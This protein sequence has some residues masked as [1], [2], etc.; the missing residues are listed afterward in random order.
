MCGIIGLISQFDKDV[1]NKVLEGLLSLQ[2]RGQDSSGISNGKLCIKDNG[3]A[4]NIFNTNVLEKLKSNIAI[5]HVRYST[6]KVKD[7]KQIQPFVIEVDYKITLVHNG[8]IINIDYMK[9][10]LSKKFGINS[11][12]NSDSEIL[13][14]IIYAKLYFEFNSVINKDTIFQIVNFLQDNLIGSFSVIIIIEDLVLVC[15]RDRYGIRPLLYGIDKEKNSHLFSSESGVYETVNFEYIRDILPGETMYI[16]NT[17]GDVYTNVNP[18]SY[19]IP[20]I[21]E[22]LYFARQDSYINEISVYQSRL[23]IGEL[24]GKTILEKMNNENFEID[25][26]VP[27]PDTSRIFALGVHNVLKKPYHEALVKNRY[28][29]RTFIL[30]NENEINKNIKR[31]LNTVDYLIKDK[32]VM[33]VDDSIVRGNTSKYVVSLLK[34]AGAKKVYIASASPPVCYPN[35]FG[36]FIESSKECIAFNRSLQEIEKILGIDKLIYNNLEDIIDVLKKLNKNV[37]DFEAS[38]F[39]NDLCYKKY[40]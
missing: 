6:T 17:T 31:K 33:V 2:H 7:D 16:S 9:Q 13:T 35:N 8:N 21:F 27:V 38:M 26:I 39:N 11:D 40:L 4:V 30:E 20:C 5:G 1:I 32:C 3:Y 14:Q 10:Y 36:I 15:F 23:L 24:L 29:D 37:V 22:Y 34:K 28:I 12:S 25:C 19:L 18:K